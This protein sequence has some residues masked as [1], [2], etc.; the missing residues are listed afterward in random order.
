V[1][2]NVLPTLPDVFDNGYNINPDCRLLGHRP[3]VSTNPLK[4]GPYVW[5]TYKQVDVRRRRI[6]S[7]L[8][9]L[10]SRGELQ[11]EDLETVGIWSQNRPGI[12]VNSHSK[13]SSHQSPQNGSLLNLLYMLIT[14]SGLVFTILLARTL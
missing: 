3:L 8:H 11:G 13:F 10:F 14:K 9:R 1:D 5:Q 2:V 12:R 4:Y 6:G 7:A